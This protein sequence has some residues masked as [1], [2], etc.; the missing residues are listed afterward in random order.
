[1]HH[2]AFQSVA[3]VLVTPPQLS[4]APVLT[5]GRFCVYTWEDAAYG[6]PFRVIPRH[7]AV[8]SRCLAGVRRFRAIARC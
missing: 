3:V 7:T 6:S 2:S 1:M 5:P 8:G 4:D